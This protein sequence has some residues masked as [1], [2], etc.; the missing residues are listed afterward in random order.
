MLIEQQA[1]LLYPN[2][3][4]IFLTFNIYLV[5]GLAFFAIFFAII[6]RDLSQSQIAIASVLPTLG[7]FGL[8]HGLHEWSE[9]YLVLF[10][11]QYGQTKYL[12]I[13]TVTKLFLSFIAMGAFAW[14]MLPLT[15]WRR[16]RLVKIACLAT[17]F[18]FIA[19]LFFRYQGQ[20]F[21]DYLSNTE[22]H[23]R[24][25]FGLG[26]SALSGT[27]VYSY[28][29]QLAEDGHDASMPFKFTGVFLILYGICAGVL[30]VELGLWV[31]FA[32]SLCAIAIL[33]S[34]WSALHIF[35]TE[36][37]QQIEDTLHKA[38]Q[39]EKLK[40]LGELTSAVSHEIKTPLSSAMMSCDLLER[41]IV[42]QPLL[43]KQLHRIRFGLERAAD[44]S[45]EVL[46]FAHH[47]PLKRHALPLAQAL[48]SAISLNQFRLENY[49]LNCLLD[50]SVMVMGD[51]GLLEEVF[52]NLIG[53]AIDATQDN[54]RLDVRLYRDKMTAVV[55]I[56]DFGQ[57]MSQEV[58]NKAFQPFFTTKPK[59]EGTGMG[60]A[61]CKQIIHQHQGEITLTNRL[62]QNQIQ[63]LTVTLCLPRITQ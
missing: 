46:N 21:A 3:M 43:H 37:H 57:G 47:R 16:V 26:A 24:L 12:E 18:G 42:D 20:Q 7:V 45:Q 2:A 34:L 4:N 9:L 28:A 49:Q 60:L 54:Q 22:Q 31:L 14:K 35:D 15:H 44:I 32:R 58:T 25:I 8:I 59:G 11:D 50:E 23:I 17:L 36:R 27:A 52:S 63:G 38:L 62:K 48:H 53:N 55:E 29:L 1:N 40:E 6:F 61:L 56:A 39:D 19:S 10:V 13:F 5:Y 33:T 51:L 41:H 30:S